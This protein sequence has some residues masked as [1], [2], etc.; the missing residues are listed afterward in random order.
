[1][2]S[3]L[4]LPDKLYPFLLESCIGIRS[5]IDTALSRELITWIYSIHPP[6]EQ[7]A[8]SKS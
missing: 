3:C 1:M 6:L 7:C 8:K 2:A 5:F 4:Y